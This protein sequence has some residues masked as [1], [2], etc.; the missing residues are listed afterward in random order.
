[1]VQISNK[2]NKNLNNHHSISS[3]EDLCSAN[4]RNW[5]YQP[6]AQDMEELKQLHPEYFI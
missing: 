6:L 2:C 5:K 1:V 3:I 4:G